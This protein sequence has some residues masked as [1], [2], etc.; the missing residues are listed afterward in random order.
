MTH[1]Q[2]EIGA[3]VLGALD[4]GLL[5]GNLGVSLLVVVAGAALV[6]ALSL[7]DALLAILLGSVLG[8]LMLA[9]AGAIGADARVPGMALM[10]APLGRRGSYLPTGINV[11]QG[12]GRTTFELLIIATAAAALSDE[13][14][15][16]RAQWLWTIAF[17]V[18]TLVLA[19]LGTLVVQGCIVRVPG[20][21]VVS[22]RP[23]FRHP[24]TLV[25]VSPGL[26]VVEDYDHAV[27]REGTAALDTPRRVVRDPQPTDDAVLHEAAEGLHRL[28]ERG[29]AVLPVRPV[30]V[31]DVDAQPPQAR[32]AAAPHHVG[33]EALDLGPVRAGHVA[34]L[35]AHLRRDLH[36]IAPR[37]RGREPGAH[38]GLARAT[39]A[40][41]VEPERVAVRGVEGPTPG[42]DEPVDERVRRRPVDARAEEHGAEDQPGDVHA[43]V[44][45]GGPQAP[46]PAAP[47]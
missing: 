42:V 15:G 40:G 20:A 12:V 41:R 17:G 10:R 26:W 14:F 22:T 43:P 24:P 18:A 35:H 28:L 27:A 32:L 45:P 36:P 9:T 29:A 16:F 31:H 47:P 19:L 30:E 3:Y 38:H 13:L 1:V 5:W 34:G 6:P 46:G 23:V 33:R 11:L 2:E 44:L 37:R 7:P 8:N 4:T 39:V 21:V 25:L